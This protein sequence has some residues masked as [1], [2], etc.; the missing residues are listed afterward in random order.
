MTRLQA[1]GWG[2]LERCSVALLSGWSARSSRSTPIAGR[3]AAAG[4]PWSEQRV[5]YGVRQRPLLSSLA[6][7]AL[8]AGAALGGGEPTELLSETPG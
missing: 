6:G 4:L 7:P 5:L 3:A 8:A 1:P 2:W